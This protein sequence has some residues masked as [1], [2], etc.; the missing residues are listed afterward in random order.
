VA[1]SDSYHFSSSAIDKLTDAQIEAWSNC[2]KAAVVPNPFFEP[3][4]KIPASHAFVREGR[5]QLFAAERNGEFAACLPLLTHSSHLGPL[6]RQVAYSRKFETSSGLG[7]PLLAGPSLTDSVNGLLD[8]LQQWSKQGGPGILMLD[9][10]DDGRDGVGGTLRDVCAFRKIP[11][12][13]RR[14]WE[15]PVVRRSAKSLSL[16]ENLSTKARG[17]LRR[18]Q[19]RLEEQLGGALVLRDRSDALAV[20]EFLRLEASGWKGKEGSAFAK[21]SDAE[22]W[23]RELCRNF[24]SLGQ[25]HMLSLEVDGRSVAMQCFLRSSTTAFSLR[26][27]HDAALNAFGPGVLLHVAAI[28]YLDTLNIDVV[29]SCTDPGNPYW[30]HLY[31]DRRQMANLVIATG[32]HLDRLA[33]KSFPMVAQGQ[34]MLRHFK[35]AETKSAESREWDPPVRGDDPRST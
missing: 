28:D 2:A 20:D 11:L 33:V 21:R 12:R 32:S 13:E 23:F 6:G 35:K 25:L 16:A 34:N 15:R 14:T 22:Q 19:R 8:A 31:P 18:R 4:C 10:L 27:G 24:A 7:S 17:E 3:S 9:W 1:P 29:D 5:A 26:V 30:A